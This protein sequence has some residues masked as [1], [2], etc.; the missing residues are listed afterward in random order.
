MRNSLDIAVIGLA[1][2]TDRAGDRQ[3]GNVSPGRTVEGHVIV[4]SICTGDCSRH[5]DRLAR[6]GVLVG[7]AA[8]GSSHCQIVTGQHATQA[9]TGHRIAITV[10]G[11]AI[12]SD[13]SV[14]RQPGNVRCSR[15]VEGHVIV[16][17]V[18]ASDN[19]GDSHRF[20]GASI[21]VAELAA[22]CHRQIV[23]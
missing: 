19:T 18:G 6:T 4:T 16:T 15:A 2:G 20:A 12:G 7:K 23:S 21:L 9:A 17:S 11:L 22:A 13:H 5:I 14:D 3:L 1:I 10:I 8:A